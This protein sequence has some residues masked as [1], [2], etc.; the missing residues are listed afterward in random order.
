MKI[1]PYKHKEKY[2]T[3]KSLTKDK[4]E[5][6][7]EENSRIV[8]DYLFDM[9]Q[10]LNVASGSKKGARSYIRLNNL[11]QRVI[12]LIKQF[13]EKYGV[14]NVTKI[15]ERHLHEFFTGMKNGSITRLDGE[16][17]RSPTDYVKVFKAF[18][19]W[20]QKINRKRGIEIQDITL[21]LD[22][23]KDKPEWVYLTEEQVKKLV[24]NS[25]YDYK[26]LMMFLY[27][28]GIRAPTELVNIKVSD[29]YN[30]FKELNIRDE[31]SKTFGRRIKLM[32]CSD[33]IKE[34]VTNKGLKPEDYIF[35]KHPRVMNRYLKRLAKRILGDAVSPA[36]QKYSELTMYDFRH[37]SCCYWLPRYKSESALKFRF[38]WKK[39]D[40]I[41]YYSEMLGMRDTISEEDLLV[42][43]T[44]TEIEHRLVKSENEK[45]MLSDRVQILEAQMNQI[46]ELVNTQREKVRLL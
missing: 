33:I 41:H 27:D 24:D 2:L 6:L 26:L 16:L 14:I 19:H 9:E 23:S 15:S 30:N 18:W 28:S 38:G 3:W 44:K 5:N 4:I 31:V 13:E 1:D 8:L 39:S 29:F 11:K 35:S 25:I 17:Y 42:D 36:G 21:D 32:L 22:T 45:E 7:S 40:K 20:H 34:Y 37:C 43:I 12:F 46:L 10:G